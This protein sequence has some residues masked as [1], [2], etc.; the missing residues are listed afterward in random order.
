[1]KERGREWGWKERR[2]DRTNGKIEKA[3]S[4]IVEKSKRNYKRKREKER[5][6]K[7]MKE[8]IKKEK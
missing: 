7:T 1:V 6:Y 4:E 5:K 3:N 2:K 8:N